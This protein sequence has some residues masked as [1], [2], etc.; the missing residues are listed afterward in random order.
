VSVAGSTFV[1]QGRT[2]EKAME[3]VRN[4][5]GEDAKV[6][7]VKNVRTGGFLGLFQHDEVELKGYAPDIAK[8]RVPVKPLDSE[9]EKKKILQ[10]A[11]VKTDSAMLEVL[12]K[13]KTI[14]QKLDGADTGLADKNEH[15]S[16]KSI[17]E[18]LLEDDFPQKYI[19][20]IA[21]RIKK[22][23]SIE[24]LDNFREV[25]YRVLEWIGEGI[26]IYQN[27]I[28]WK[29]P[30]IIVL[31][32][33]T[34]SGK[35]TTVA[36]LAANLLLGR[37]T[38]TA[39]QRVCVINIDLFKVGA[40]E[41]IQKY[42]EI[43]GIPVVSVQSADEM[44]REIALAVDERD[45][46]IV[47]TIGKSPRENVA[48][49]DMKQILAGC[50]REAEVYLTLS[51]NMKTRDLAE[52]MRQF[53]PFGYCA[54]IVTKMDETSAAGNIISAVFDKEKSISWLTD[55]QNVPKDIREASVIQLLINLE[56]FEVDRE[57]LDARFPA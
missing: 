22:D 54:V 48:L 14:E 42:G 55:G 33:P 36:K 52:V 8:Y 9:A 12:D 37:F 49:A 19:D 34:G 11:P 4:I 18:L 5:H 20:M 45:V 43:M 15:Q 6:L 17:R 51:A 16:I 10:M 31:L 25:Q 56:G 7:E 13:L 3:M 1:V 2:Y 50:G 26:S 38:G 24:V 39:P 44:K 27:K 53:E 57:R 46:I 40:E 41:Q 32:G 47:D 30:R 21:A 29:K 35:T 28:R 23:L